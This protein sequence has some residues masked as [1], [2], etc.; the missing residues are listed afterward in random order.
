MLTLQDVVLE[1]ALLAERREHRLV[2]GRHRRLGE[3]DGR[4]EKK[5]GETSTHTDLLEDTQI[6]VY[7]RSRSRMSA[8][9]CV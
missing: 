8:V 3:C 1:V 2:I 7:I 5:E 9:P 6:R 4:E